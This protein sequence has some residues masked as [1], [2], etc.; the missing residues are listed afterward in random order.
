MQYTCAILLSVASLALQ[1]FSHL[2]NATVFKKKKVVG[3][4]LCVFALSAT[5][6][7]TCLILRRTAQ[8]MIINMDWSSS[9]VPFVLVGF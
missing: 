6:C 1:Y 3:H 8:Y 2:I 5:L 9:K 4:K 7:E